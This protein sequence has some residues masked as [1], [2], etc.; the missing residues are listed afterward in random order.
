MDIVS[1]INTAKDKIRELKD[2]SVGSTQITAHIIQKR[3]M[4]KK[5]KE[6]WGTCENLNIYH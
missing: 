1:Y 4:G 3:I 5:K 2:R 6:S